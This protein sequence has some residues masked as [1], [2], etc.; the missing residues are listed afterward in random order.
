MQRLRHDGESELNT[1]A[2]LAEIDV[3]DPGLY[4]A[5]CWRP[6]FARLRAEDPVHYCADSPF[7]PYW[8][9]TRFND[10]LEVDGDHTI[11]SAEPTVMIGDLG[12]G[13][14]R[15]GP[16]QNF[17]SQDPPIHDERRAVVTPAVSPRN[18]HQMESLIRERVCLILDE[19]PR[20]ETFDWVSRVGVDLT[21]RMLATLFDF[22]QEERHKLIYWSDAFVA[23]PR[24]G[25]NALSR[26]ER[27]AAIREAMATFTAMFRQRAARPPGESMDL[28]SMLAHGEG[29]SDMLDRPEELLGNIILLVVGGH[30]TTRNSIAGGVLGGRPVGLELPRSSR[31]RRVARGLQPPHHPAVAW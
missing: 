19:L 21:S 13:S 15:Y 3:S 2:N 22:P 4:E 8:S 7:G 5:D 17:I 23:D 14:G 10:I 27:R 25:G 18:L 16:T 11:W 26:D 24:I 9:I 30:D 6:L 1:V 28:I 29:T 31:Q 12:P 20:G